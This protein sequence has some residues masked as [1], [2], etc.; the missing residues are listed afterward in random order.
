M[1]LPY[2]VAKENRLSLPMP[3]QSWLILADDLTGAA[4][5]AIA[6]ARHGQRA[7]V[8]WDSAAATPE[9]VTAIDAHSRGLTSEQAA[10]R[11]RSLLQS[12][13]R[14]GLRLFKKI[15]STMRGQPAAELAETIRALREAGQGAFAVVAPAFPE[16]GRTT[17]AGAIRLHG[18][19][20]EHTALWARDRS[21]LSAD[22]VAVLTAAGLRS[23]NVGLDRL[24]DG[25]LARLLDEGVAA[26]LDALVCDAVTSEDMDLIAQATL[27]RAGSLFW[28]GSG[29]LAL[30]L[31][32]AEGPAVMPETVE[33][34]GGILF[35]VGSIAES[36][37]AA[38]AVLAA[39]PAVITVT[40]TPAALRAGADGTDW[41]SAATR[42]A[43]GLKAKRDVLVLIAPD[44]AADL[45]Q[46]A[47]LAQCLGDMLRPA[48]PDIGALFATGG[49][50]ARA[51]LT[52]LSVTG[53]R[54]IAEIEPGV[55]LG[56]TCGA[57]KV[58]VITKAG[59]FGDAGTMQR[60][61]M[62]FRDLRRREE[63][64]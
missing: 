50:T 37:R 64:S 27:P 18:Q 57:V 49:E 6:F 47:A 23:G 61:L 51:L 58:P 11:H 4:D 53:I 31:A 63:G 52:A 44:Y 7:M 16:T 41:Q 34:G 5:C 35:V 1:V 17:E 28:T 2:R 14:P 40:V 13:H 33:I 8:Q 21:Y 29:G 38:A 30:A 55:P 12:H 22:I 42:I 26:G 60:C 43:G 3:E 48:A 54:L 46:G 32:R 39:D 20:L 59:A 56:L 36:S 62:H 19:A 15:D 45:S 9:P 25:G 10:S 24:R